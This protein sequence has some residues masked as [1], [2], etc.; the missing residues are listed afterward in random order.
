M[1]KKDILDII[2][3]LAILALVFT[4]LCKGTIYIVDIIK[5]SP[6]VP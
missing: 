1:K 6:P 5:L 2:A 3:I 4:I